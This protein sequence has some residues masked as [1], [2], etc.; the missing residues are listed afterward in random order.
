M[1]LD[2]ISSSIP[3]SRDFLDSL[4]GEQLLAHRWP[5]VQSVSHANIVDVNSRGLS[6]LP[7]F[8]DEQI[9]MLEEIPSRDAVKTMLE[10]IYNWPIETRNR[11]QISFQDFGVVSF[12]ALESFS[13]VQDAIDIT[14]QLDEMIKWLNHEST[15]F[16]EFCDKLKMQLLHFKRP[17]FDTFQSYHGVN[18]STREVLSFRGETRLDDDTILKLL[19]MLEATQGWQ[20]NLQMFIIPPLQFELHTTFVDRPDFWCPIPWKSGKE[21][22]ME[23][24]AFADSDPDNKAFVFTMAKIGNNWGGAFCIDIRHK[25]L[26]FGR[27]LDREKLELCD[28]LFRAAYRW[29]RACGVAVTG[30]EVERFPVEQQSKSSGSCS[31]AALAAIERF[32]DPSI[33]KW[34]P[35][36]SRYHRLRLLAKAIRNKPPSVSNPNDADVAADLECSTMECSNTLDM[37]PVDTAEEEPFVAAEAIAELSGKSLE[38]PNNLSADHHSRKEPNTTDTNASYETHVEAHSDPGEQSTTESIVNSGVL[39]EIK[40]TIEEPFVGR[41]YPD[42]ETAKTKL[43]E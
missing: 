43:K 2:H 12:V 11:V 5:R 19:M 9:E 37:E 26:L 24:I 38:V 16:P 18:L 8:S 14:L 28:N 4:T 27:S 7:V 39:P 21:R 41:L 30:W 32:L 20:A 15:D 25:R 31:V 17:M 22:L 6:D 3:W 10:E 33:E 13:R 40:A 35:E 1:D 23:L 36:E 29:L 34:S 42:L